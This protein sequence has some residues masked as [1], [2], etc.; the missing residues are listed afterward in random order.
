MHLKPSF[1]IIGERKCGT[2]SLYRYLL[3]H[4]NVLPCQLKE[5]QFFV[6]PLWRIILGIRKY[7]RLFP[8]L[9]HQ[10]DITVNWPELD[11]EG[12][13]FFETLTVERLP[14]EQYITGEASAE[15]F[16]RAK[17]KVLQYFLPEIKLI[18]LL[19]NPVERTYSHYRML[20][21]YQK[22]GRKTAVPLTN[23][24]DDMR[25]EM[26][27]TRKGRSSFFI[28]P[29]LYIN[30]LSVWQKVFG[31]ENLKVILTEQL[32]DAS[33]AI[34][35]MNQLCSYLK[36]PE[37]DFSNILNER[38]NK[39]PQ[40]GV[41]SEIEAELYDF[42]APYNQALEDLLEIKLNWKS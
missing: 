10:G 28:G 4:P 32:D 3:Y 8:S 23:F 40:K 13:L 22:M 39:A 9:E 24:E 35:T 33:L 17:P 34:E 30:R 18:L 7:Y 41:P 29:S 38:Y 37:Y 20:E 19:R 26:E 16:Y 31:K 12:K 27:D 6:K 5:P 1:Y 14:E 15:T 36:L 2:S 25:R 11:K 21:R 42:F